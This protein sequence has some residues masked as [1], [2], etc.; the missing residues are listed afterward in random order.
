MNHR[1]HHYL[2]ETD[3]TSCSKIPSSLEHVQNS[4]RTYTMPV[5]MN[6]KKL[7]SESTE[8]INKYIKI[9]CQDMGTPP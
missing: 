3:Y 9:K 4:L 2:Q 8:K 7:I 6:K 1:V 5:I